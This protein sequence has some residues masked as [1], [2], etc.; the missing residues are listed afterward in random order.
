MQTA[1]VSTTSFKAQTPIV[2]KKSAAVA[3]NEEQN[4]KAIS[5]KAAA[6]GGAVLLTAGALAFRKYSL[7]R[8]VL[9]DVEIIKEADSIKTA[10]S[11]VLDFAR[12]KLDE[13]V[14]FIQ[15]GA[16]DGYQKVE[17]GSGNVVR[18]FIMSTKSR[19]PKQMIEYSKDGSQTITEFAVINNT[20]AV[21]PRSITQV[22]NRGEQVNNIVNSMLELRV[23]QTKGHKTTD[24]AFRDNQLQKAVVTLANPD[25]SG[26]ER[27][28]EF[29]DGLLTAAETYNK[30]ANNTSIISSLKN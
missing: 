20:G 30:Y 25:G 23:V 3:G 17:D 12:K 2:A 4:K 28:F 24:L 11:N 1:K 5:S 26:F 13:A 9:S 10:A 16:N 18:E 6:I 29:K 21:I 14:E 7:S 19:L 15:K 27:T 22:N 8:K